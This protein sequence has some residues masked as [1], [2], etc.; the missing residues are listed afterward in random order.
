MVIMDFV[1]F[2]FSFSEISGGISDDKG[3][4]VVLF[5]KY[6]VGVCVIIYFVQSLMDVE[7]IFFSF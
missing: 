1:V 5:Q 4:K 6:S 2:P 3:A 7:Y